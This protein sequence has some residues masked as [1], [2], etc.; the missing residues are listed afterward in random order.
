MWHSKIAASCSIS[1]MKMYFLNEKD[2]K[3]S[4]YN[5]CKVFSIKSNEAQGVS[6]ETKESGTCC[7]FYCSGLCFFINPAL[8]LVTSSICAC[9]RFEAKPKETNSHYL[10]GCISHA[11]FHSNIFKQ[12]CCTICLQSKSLWALLLPSQS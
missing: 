2:L 11:N 10:K 8:K 3:V 7:Y 4:I 5:I 9:S 1:V 6:E 12:R